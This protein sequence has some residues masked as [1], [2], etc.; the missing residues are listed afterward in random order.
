MILNWNKIYESRGMYSGHGSRGACAKKKVTAIEHA[1]AINQP[2]SILD[3]GCGD[4]FVIKHVDLTGVDYVG[5]DS[6]QFAID[7]LKAQSGQL[8]VFCEDFFEFDFNRTFDLVVCLDVLIHLDDPIDYRRFTERLKRF[9]VKSILVSGYTQATPE[10][11]KSKVIH[12]HESLMQTFAGYECEKL[13]EYR[14]TTLLL[15][16][17][18][19]HRDRKHTIWTYWETMKNHTRPKYLDLC[20]ETWHHQCGDDFEIVRVS[21]ENIQQY[22]PDI[23]PEWHGIQCLAHKADY[24]R[25]VLVHRY[26]G[27]WLDSD[28]IALSNLS[29]VMD[30]LHESGSDFIGCGRPGNRPSNG[31]FGGKAGSILLGKYIE[32]MDA[33]IQSRNNNLR[34]KW[35][36]LGYNL[37]WPLTKNYSYFQYDFRICIPIHPSRFRAYFDHRSLDE[38][39]AAD[40][41]IRQ[42]TLVAYLYNA[43]FPVW[44]KQLPIDS[45]LRSSMVISQIIRRGLSIANWQEYNNNEHLFDQMKALGHRNNI[46]SMLRRAG[47]NHHVCEIGVRAGQNLDQIVQGSKPSEFVGIDSWDSGEIS[48]QNDVG[49]SQVKQDQLE[50]QVRNKFAKYGER[51]RIIRGYFFEV[52]SQF[53]DGYFDYIY[54]DADHSYE[55]V[56]RDLEDWYPKVRTGGILAGHD[57]IAKDSKHVK[58]GVIEAVDEFVRNHNV[59]FFATTPEN[60]SSWLMLKQGMPRTP[61]FCYWSIGFGSVDHHAMLCSLV[62]SA[63]S[64]GVEEDFHIWTDH[65]ITIPGSEIHEIDRPCN[66]SLRNMFKVE[67]LKNLNK[68]EYDYYV[69]L[70]P[71]NYFTRKPS[72]ESIHTLLQLADPLHLS[73][74]SKIN[75]EAFSNAQTQSWQWRGIT[76]Q[77]I[78]D[79]WAERGMEEKSVYNLNGG[80]FVIKRD[81]W[82]KVYDACWEGFHAVKN[83]KG[84]EQIADE[85]AF[86]Y[87]MTKLTNPDGHQIKDKHVNDVWAVDRGNYRNKLPD[88]KPFPFWT[89]WNGQKFMVDP[90]IVRAMKSKPQLIEYGKANS[91]ETSCRS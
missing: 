80:F 77:D 48:S 36:E 44:F 25:A 84:I 54:I 35:T 9:A 24:L 72:D 68:Y 78:V 7:Q 51:G 33:L 81:E 43:M 4:Q 87:A 56:K 13:A 32:S 40:C 6:S 30:R 5:I 79:I 31:F 10:I 22:V 53:P 49:F 91:I 55:A 17:L 74:E 62:Q 41:D 60:Y 20:E 58:Y 90:A 88:G 39:S 65:G 15:V 76:L 42:D 29:P 34:F 71:D 18:Q 86:A 75:D 85:L 73:V 26:G 27:L 50:S 67:V 1:I 19:K 64:V 14:D 12:F 3:V 8:N 16:N 38:L 61:S 2:K 89:N 82:K 23:I 28:M 69:F 83:K 59:R 70:D 46:P 11:T 66:P 47:L 45:V 21:P 52:C 63:R 57:Y 37:L